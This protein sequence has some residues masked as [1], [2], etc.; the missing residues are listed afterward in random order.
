MNY[1]DFSINK[2][3]RK[4]KCPKSVFAN[5]WHRVGTVP[6][7]SIL[8]GGC[9]GDSAREICLECGKVFDEPKWFIPIRQPREIRSSK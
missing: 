8:D 2:H 3:P 7:M 6:I 5:R 4:G 9:S 1:E